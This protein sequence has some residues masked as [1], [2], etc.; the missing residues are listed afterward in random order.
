MK[1][2]NAINKARHLHKRGKGVQNQNDI[3]ILTN[4]ETMCSTDVSEN[5][6]SSEMIISLMKVKQNLFKATF[7]FW[8][9]YIM[10]AKRPNNVMSNDNNLQESTA[11]LH[12]LPMIVLVFNRV[13]CLMI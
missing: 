13:F 4:Y 7:L 3:M 12:L 8:N 11:M 5:Y 9:T 10:Y 2:K 1:S 6:S